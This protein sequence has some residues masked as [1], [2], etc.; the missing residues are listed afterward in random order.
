VPAQETSSP[1]QTWANADESFVS[2]LIE[3]LK[4]EVRCRDNRIRA[5][6]PHRLR[7]MERSHGTA[8]TEASSGAPFPQSGPGSDRERS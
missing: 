6:L 1:P 5:F 2:P 3:G 7:T 8:I 4:D